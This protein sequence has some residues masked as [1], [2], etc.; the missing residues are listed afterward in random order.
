MVTD[1]ARVDGMNAQSLKLIRLNISN[2][3]ACLR[4]RGLV[5]A[6]ALTLLVVSTPAVD[7]HE[8]CIDPVCTIGHSG[9]AVEVDP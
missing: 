1:A 2:L 4:D 7:E 6:R 3:L 9:G 8:L 5:V